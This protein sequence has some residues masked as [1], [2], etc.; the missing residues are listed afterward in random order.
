MRLTTQPSHP[1]RPHQGSPQDQHKRPHSWTAEAAQT[2][3]KLVT[4][5]KRSLACTSLTLVKLLVAFPL[6]VGAP[7]IELCTAGWL[8]L[9]ITAW[10][11]FVDAA[12]AG[13]GVADAAAEEAPPSCTA[14]PTSLCFP[15]NGSVGRPQLEPAVLNVRPYMRQML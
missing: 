3:L 4:V 12:V 8:V 13:A 14:G 9:G 15:D 6:A 10:L 5:L 1:Q 2:T 11:T 7:V